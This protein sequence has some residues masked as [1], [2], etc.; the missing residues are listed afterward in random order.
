MFEQ[1]RACRAALAQER[2]VPPYVIF[3][4][5]TLIE[6]ATRFPLTS[7]ALAQIYGVGQHKVEQYGAHFL[8]IIQEYCEKN[9][10][11]P[12]SPAP[13]LPSRP[14][15]TGQQR[16]EHIWQQYQNGAP[17][18]EIAAEMGFTPNTILQHLSKAFAAGKALDP[19]GLIAS[20]KV[21]PDE[22]PRVRAAFAEYGTQYLKPVFDALNEAVPY[23]ELHLWRLIVQIQQ[24]THEQDR[25]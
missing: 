14:S 17:L 2:G 12:L 8:P 5:R 6:M 7:G 19:G 21:S 22:H 23:E 18:T 13:T 3:H 20:S 11:N 1:L 15:L 9:D 24:A 4:D 25:E 10:V 16:T